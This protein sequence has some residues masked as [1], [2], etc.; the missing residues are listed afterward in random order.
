M[1]TKAICILLLIFLFIV[2]T[3]SH[4]CICPAEAAAKT[5]ITALIK[6]VDRCQ[7]CGHTRTCCIE[8]Q[9][10]ELLSADLTIGIDMHIGQATDCRFYIDAENG[11]AEPAQNRYTNKAPPWSV[12][13]TPVSLHQKLVV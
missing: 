1:K 7:D 2:R 6:K 9:D 13:Q 8:Q 3:G 10:V 11:F 5:A 4:M 12:Q